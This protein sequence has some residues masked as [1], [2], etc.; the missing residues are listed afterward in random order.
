MRE[1][2]ENL[3]TSVRKLEGPFIAFRVGSL[4]LFALIAICVPEAGASR[5]WLALYCLLVSLPMIGLELYLPASEHPSVQPLFDCLA[6]SIGAMLFPDIW[7]SAFLVGVMAANSRMLIPDKKTFNAIVAAHLILVVGMTCAALVHRV[8]GWLVPVFAT[9]AAMPA[10]LIYSHQQAIR[11]TE[12][13]LQGDR[14]YSLR[15]L[16]DGVAHDFNNLL[17]GIVVN[18]NVASDRLGRDHEAAEALEGVLNATQYASMLTRQ[19][20]DLTSERMVSDPVMTDVE[21]ELRMLVRLIRSMIPAG[22]EIELQRELSPPPLVSLDRVKLQRVMMNLILNSA[23]A[24][25]PPS[26]IKVELSHRALSA[27]Q[28]ELVICITDQGCGI[29]DRELARIFE[30]LVTSK[31]TG[32]GMGLANA[33]RIIESEG[34]T[35]TASSQVGEGTKMTVRLPVTANRGAFPASMRTPSGTPSETGAPAPR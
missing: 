22:I 30:P 28:L 12:E 9:L 23:E 21:F 2:G 31:P 1:A 33:K 17:C 20:R 19:L 8:D 35:I 29:G 26:T 27:R 18:A 13:K 16:A 3:V 15:L 10:V 6:C 34:G 24:V 14:Q 32:S 11:M 25:E 5:H 4:L 7:T